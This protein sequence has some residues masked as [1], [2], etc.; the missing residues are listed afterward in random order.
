MENNLQLWMELLELQH[1]YVAALD[2]NELEAWPA[3]FLEEGHYEIIPKEN[4]DQGLPVPV[5][6]CRNAR[7]MRDR[8]VSLRNAN[9]YEAHTYRHA[10]SGLVIKGIED[11]VVTTHSNYVVVST[12]TAGDT[13]VYQAGMYID[14]VVKHEGQWRYRSKKV[15]YDTLRVQTLLATPI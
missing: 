2:A 7:M 9:I 1:R 8:V 15:V 13:V 4:Y 12:G 3:F 6:Y 5:I 11:D 14:E 10:T